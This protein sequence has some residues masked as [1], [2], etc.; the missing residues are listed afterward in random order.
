MV[1][2]QCPQC[3]QTFPVVQQTGR[4]RKYCTP[5]CAGVAAKERRQKRAYAPADSPQ[6]CASCHLTKEAT[7]FHKDIRRSSGLY[8]YCKP[9][10][11]IHMGTS[12]RKPSPWE[13]KTAYEK[14]RR[15]RLKEAPDANERWRRRHLWDTYRIT[16]EDY[17]AM[18]ARQGGRCAVCGTDDPPSSGRHDSEYRFAVDHDHSCC[19]GRRSCGDCVRGL[20]CNLC[21]VGLGALRDDRALLVKAIDYLDAFKLSDQLA[22]IG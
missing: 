6:E 10:R 11:R 21:N 16:P 5:E 7:E 15:E 22:L 12:E 1:E 19:D 20:L 4:S 2:K 17:Q 3:E 13:S 9:C 18:L 14:K 8:P